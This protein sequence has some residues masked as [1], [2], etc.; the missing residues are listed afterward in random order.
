[1]VEAISLKIGIAVGGRKKGCLNNDQVKQ[2]NKKLL[3]IY[4]KKRNGKQNK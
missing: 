1:M 2:L 4:L 3:E